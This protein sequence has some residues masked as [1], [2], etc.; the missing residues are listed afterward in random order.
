MVE[1]VEQLEHPCFSNGILHSSWSIDYIVCMVFRSS[2]FYINTSPS[3]YNP[4]C[5]VNLIMESPS[6]IIIIISLLR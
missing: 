6:L 4:D 2:D 1:R 5:T 3:S